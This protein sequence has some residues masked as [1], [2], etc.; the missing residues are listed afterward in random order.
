M[1]AHNTKS[2][3]SARSWNRSRRIFNALNDGSGLEGTLGLN[4]GTPHS[5]SMRFT[6]PLPSPSLLRG[7]L[8]LLLRPVALSR[9]IYFLLRPWG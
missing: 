1:S 6:T 2:S 8:C 7:N 9:S 5:T 3:Q 4:P